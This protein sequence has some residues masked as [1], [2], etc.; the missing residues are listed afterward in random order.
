MRGPGL[1]RPAAFATA[2][3]LGL[4]GCLTDPPTPG[5]DATPTAAPDPTPVVSGYVLDRT[6]WYGGFVLTFQTASASLDAKGGPVTVQLLLGNP[7]EDE[8]TLD[9]P[10][11]LVSGDVA[12]EPSR[13]TDL[14]LVGG[15]THEAATLVFEVDAAFDVAGAAIRVGRAEEHQAIV[16]M[17][18]AAET[19]VTL[20]PRYVELDVQGVAG[21]LS[22]E[23]RRL[24]LRTDL[25]D[26]RQQLE[27]EILALTLTYDA[28]FASDFIGG[29]AFTAATVS[30]RLPDGTFV[31]PRRDGHSQSVLVIGPGVRISGLQS[32]FEVP[33]PG[34]GRYALVIR[35]GSATK[36]LPFE[37]VAPASPG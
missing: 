1:R 26:W 16:P 10:I 33:A 31:E 7:G 29:F 23:L 19:S 2:V 36:E 25:P 32:R 20:A 22:V 6:I 4:V 18:G 35:D 11:A 15:G 14:P 37:I 3:A 12:V 21:S 17:V 5:P 30:L 13:E 28:R 8:A 9:G 27:R 34:V 24:E